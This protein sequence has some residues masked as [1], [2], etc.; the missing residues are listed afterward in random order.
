MRVGSGR[1]Q[2]PS[3]RHGHEQR[4]LHEP[5][6]GIHIRA[7]AARAH[8]RQAP[9]IIAPTN[10]RPAPPATASTSFQVGSPGPN[11]TRRPKRAHRGRG[12]RTT[13]PVSPPPM[14]TRR[15]PGVRPPLRN[16]R[17]SAQTS[18]GPPPLERAARRP[19]IEAEH[20]WASPAIAPIH[21]RRRPPRRRGHES[22]TRTRAR[23]RAF[24]RASGF[25]GRR[26]GNPPAPLAAA[27]DVRFQ[28]RG[29]VESRR[30][31]GRTRR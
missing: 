24:L 26:R 12:T 7:V 5:G 1:D 23:P 14:W 17:P 19:A 31:G 16:A 27:C 29:D 4:R 2:A 18:P 10:T 15:P 11:S 13:G 30:F 6:T 20:V 22:P 25:R 8:S 3:D 28:G 9:P 21:N